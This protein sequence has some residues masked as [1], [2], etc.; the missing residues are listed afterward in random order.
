MKI[1][2]FLITALLSLSLAGLSQT[3]ETVYLGSVIKTGYADD[4][5]YGPFNIGFT[6]TFFGNTYT[7]FYVNS[8]GQILFG[9]GA[10][11]GDEVAIPNAAAPN[12]FIAALWDDLIVSSSGKIL[13]TT[14]GASPNRK[15]IIQATNMGFYP[16][17]IFMGTFL[18][19]LQE[20]SNKIQIQYRIIIDNTSDRAHGGSATIGL[21]NSTGS[22]GVQYAYHSNTAISTGKAISFTP[23]GPT[24]TIDANA[25]YDPVVLTTNLTLPEPGIPNLLSPPQDAVIGSDYTFI[26]GESEN[27][28]SYTLLI[29][30]FS[31]L[32]APVINVN[33]G[34]NLSYDVTGLDLDETYYWGVFASNGTGTTWCEIQRFYT[35]S[36]APLVAVPQTAWVEQ[37]QE[38]TI[39]L[40]YT[41]GDAGAKTATVTSLPAQGQLWQVSGG[42]KSVQIATVPAQVT[43]PQFNVIYA[44]NGGAG[45]GIGNFNF[46]FHDGTGDSPSAT[47][48][49]NV[50]PPGMPSL[51]YTGKSTTYIEMQFDRPMTDPAGKQDQF[52]IT[53][54]GLPVTV[55]SLSLKT[56]DS[57]TIIATL[58]S[59]IS[60]SDAVTVAYTAGNIT[61]V[62]GGVLATFDPQNVTLLAQTI[63]FTTNLTRKYSE[64][65]FTLAATA[66]SSLPVTFSSSNLTVAT[67]A[68]TTVTLVSVGNSNITVRQAG[69]ATYAPANFTRVLTVLKGDQTVTFDPLE[70][71]TYGD[72]DFTVSASSSSG[73]SVTFTSSDPAVA[74]VTG[75]TVHITGG[76]TTTITATQAGNTLWNPASTPQPLTVNKADLTFTMENEIKPYLADIPVFLWL[77]SGFLNGD[78]QTDINTLPIVSTTATT[79]SPVGDYPIT[80]SG[81]SDNSYNFIFVDGTLTITKIDQAITFTGFPEKILEKDT[82][83]LEASS[84]SG[85]PVLFE[86]KNT[87]VATVSG[88]QLTAVKPGTAEIRAYLDASQNYN[89]AETSVTIEVYNTHRNVV[90]LFTPNNDGY[91]DLWILPELINLGKCDV[92]VYSRSGKLV[93]SDPDY[94]N[95]WDGTSDGTPVPEGAYYFLI[96]T[97]NAGS[98][99]G[100]VNIVR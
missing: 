70:D 27:A 23:S 71:K 94:K 72:D 39:K 38:K 37:N 55:S 48:T 69:N 30:K 56:G 36:A 78:D 88:S 11:T 2:S 95:D 84:T 75:T 40:N 1:R 24:Y 46:F 10:S 74:T 58:A 64:F 76:G 9:A 33:T 67:I 96:I 4:E 6:F 25:D 5:S 83:N 7:Q 93:F 77:I 44:A 79:S 61:S 3:G 87:A 90:N 19:T 13:Y 73:L 47:V 85:L 57:N 26:W 35:S 68:G 43:D 98:Y 89:A 63:T 12:N 86:S 16:N 62:Q 28:A 45:N 31:D 81:G 49:V 41:G 20:T 14:I 99:K 66:S 100:T 92:K 82:Y 15:L 54:N 42:A 51:L 34:T 32:G 29:S 53:V 52:T 59:S 22:A 21:E 65:S 17:P 80:L 8:N 91:N 97:Q 60:L 50:S 18:V